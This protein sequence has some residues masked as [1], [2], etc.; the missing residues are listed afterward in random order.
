MRSEENGF[1][2]NGATRTSPAPGPKL[3]VSSVEAGVSL[4]EVLVAISIMGICFAALFSGFSTALRTIDRIQRSDRA[5]TFAKEKLDELLLDPTLEAGEVRSGVS[6]SGLTWQARTLE[7]DQRQGA[8]PDKPI[9]LMRVRLEVSW[10]ASGGQ[11]NF[12]LE[13]LKLRIPET[14]ATP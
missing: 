2:R 9:Q 3:R 5:V 12:R 14:S 13:S 7:A 4:L 11:Q 10:K 1:R 6:S 8:D